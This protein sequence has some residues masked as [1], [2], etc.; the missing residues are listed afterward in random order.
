MDLDE[1]ILADDDR[2]VTSAVDRLLD[3]GVAALRSGDPELYEALAA[4]LSRQED[5]LVLVAAS[6]VAP[7]S[8]LACHASVAVNATAEGYPG[9]RYHAGCQEVDRIEQLAIDRA[10]VLFGARYANVQPH[11]ASTANQTV[12]ASLLNPGDTILGMDLASG[13][14]LSHGAKPAFSGQYFDARRYG[15]DSTGRIDFGQVARLAEEHRPRL[16]ICGATAYS[17]VVDWARFR[18]IADHVGAWLLADISHIAGLVVTGLHP[19]PINH[20]HVTTACTHKQL[21]GPRGGLILLGRDA[22]SPGPNGRTLAQ[23][24]ARGVFPFFQGAPIVPAVAAKA[25]ALAIAGTAEFAAVARRIVDGASTLAA[26][27]AHR[28]YRLVSGGTDNHIVLLDLRP[29]VITGLV[30][31]RALEEA[32]VVVNKNHVPQDPAPAYVTSGLRLGTNTLAFRGLG[33][34]EFDECADIL[35]T[36]LAA[37]TPLREHRYHLPDTVKAAALARVEAL[38]ARFP[39]PSYPKGRALRE[40]QDV[41]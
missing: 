26:S 35:D 31:E 3:T 11:S 15:L 4:E 25:R 10:R 28:G 36:V 7:P 30:A 2:T 34:A 21:F 22:D 12:L 23:T 1:S 33:S 14:H 18:A 40:R 6:S 29:A 8:V 39:I 17:R 24:F 38:C 19:S 9:R 13:G 27:L 37:L 32:G 16:I 20:A 41:P 5:R